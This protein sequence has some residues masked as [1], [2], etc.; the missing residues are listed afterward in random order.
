MRRIFGSKKWEV[1]EGLIK[2]IMGIYI[3]ETST[4]G[5]RLTI[6]VRRG[7]YM[8]YIICALHN[9]GGGDKIKGDETDG[10][11]RKHGRD[12]KCKYATI[13]L[14]KS[15][16]KRLLGGFSTVVVQSWLGTE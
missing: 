12:E 10:S 8:R 6:D 1:T 7:L 15:E 16:G 4:F 5:S 9:I 14:G 11:C 2:C 3:C 13:I